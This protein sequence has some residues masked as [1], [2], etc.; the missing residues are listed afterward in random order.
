MVKCC[1][2]HAIRLAVRQGVCSTKWYLRVFYKTIPPPFIITFISFPNDQKHLLLGC[3]MS[4]FT[5]FDLKSCQLILSI[6]KYG[7][8]PCTT[9]LAILSFKVVFGTPYSREALLS[10][11]S[12]QLFFCHI[13]HR[14]I[15]PQ[16]SPFLCIVMSESRFSLIP[17]C[18][19]QAVLV[20]HQ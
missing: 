19:S 8:L 7:F 2:G 20:L 5:Y 15:A 13:D 14:F 9:L 16:L 3:S 17:C 4:H 6:V 1:L 11:I 10:P 18:H 12:E